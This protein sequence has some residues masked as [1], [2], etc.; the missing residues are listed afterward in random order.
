MRKHI[1]MDRRELLGVLGTTAGVLA[2]GATRGVFAD[3]P[4][5]PIHD[6]GKMHI[7]CLEA[8]GHCSAV[9]DESARHCLTML[10]GGKGDAKYHAKAH[11]LA[12]DCA[13][14]C[15]LSATMIARKSELMADSCQACASA[16]NACAR[17]CEK[18]N[19]KEMKEC[20]DACRACEKSCL[21]M[22]E[23]MKGSSEP[24][25]RR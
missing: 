16:C 5:I 2:L 7:S 9:C 13:M 12:A 3:E 24:A 21:A 19:A 25:A 23:H 18:S 22:V 15:T 20:A 6:H 8:C 1:P 14:F 17:E 4:Q 11:S 10:A